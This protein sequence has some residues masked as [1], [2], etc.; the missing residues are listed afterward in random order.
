M[1][2][3]LDTQVLVYSDP[4]SEDLSRTVDFPKMVQTS[5]LSQWFVSSK[6]FFDMEFKSILIEI[7]PANVL[8]ISFLE[9]HAFCSEKNMSCAVV[10]KWYN[11]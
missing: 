5:L 1:A 6:S 8:L 10:M 7:I 11:I 2:L 9:T 4:S 3:N